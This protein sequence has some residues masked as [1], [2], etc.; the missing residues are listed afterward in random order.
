MKLIEYPDRD[1]LFLRVADL[2]AGELRQAL[3]V[4]DR[5]TFS[6]PGGTTPGPVFDTLAALPLDWDRV[7]VLLCDERWVPESSERSN[8]AL[9]RRRLLTGNAAA[10]TFY[11]LWRDTP[12]PDEA[13]AE[14]EAAVAP[15]LPI[16]VLLL[17]M[18]D[19]MHTASIFPDGD[20]LADALAADAPALLPMRRAGEDEHRITLSMRELQRAMQIH[21]LI[22]GA[23]KKEA[24]ER[25]ATLSPDQ[26]PIAALLNAATF[27]WAE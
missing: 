20:R 8:A 21:V 5:V 17:G 19:D 3:S 11:P 12:A 2:I 16:S 27:H 25:A 4:Q 24:L 6:V 9:V 22:T 23:A 15:V 26:A 18:G 7:D 13:L 1:F 10:A 14:V